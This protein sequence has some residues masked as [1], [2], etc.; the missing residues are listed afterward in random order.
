[1]R[2]LTARLLKVGAALILAGVIVLEWSL[3]LP[4]RP[5]YVAMQAGPTAPV[6]NGMTSS[7]APEGTTAVPAYGPDIKAG[8][9]ALLPRSRRDAEP[10]PGRAGDS[11]GGRRITYALRSVSDTLLSALTGDVHSP[12]SADVGPTRQ[13]D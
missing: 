12:A 9:H 7:N 4:G 10:L 13:R 1:M 11:E 2:R 5:F 8:V 6:K 3:A